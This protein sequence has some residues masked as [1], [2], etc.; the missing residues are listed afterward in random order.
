[1]EAGQIFHNNPVGLETSDFVDALIHAIR[2]D[3]ARVYWN[4]NQKPWR[5][6]GPGNIGYVDHFSKEWESLSYDPGIPGIEWREYYNWGGS[7]EDADWDQSE[8]DK[9]NFS[10]EGVR[11]R[12]YKRFG[13]SMNVNVVWPAEKWQ[14]W[15]ER[16]MQTIRAYEQQTANWNHGADLLPYPDPSG[17]VSLEPTAEDLRYVEL[18]QQVKTL[19]AQINC[20]ACVCIDVENGKRPQFEKKDWRWCHA[21]EWVTRLGIHALRTPGFKLHALTAS[22]EPPTSDVPNKKGD[23]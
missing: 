22:T 12:W 3:I 18:I 4:I 5:G 15:F 10:F 11:I 19:K 17:I 23:L 8:A 20:I 7:P 16:I 9:P 13:R 21:L 14:R 1:M 2:D 6:A